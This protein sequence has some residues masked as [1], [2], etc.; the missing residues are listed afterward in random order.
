M[1]N[2]GGSR[3]ATTQ[4]ERVGNFQCNNNVNILMYIIIID[5]VDLSGK[6]S[7]KC[8]VGPS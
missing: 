3:H 6:L 1:R 4:S 5:V 2:Q 7:A 8:V